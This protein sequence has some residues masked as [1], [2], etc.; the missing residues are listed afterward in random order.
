MRRPS[1]DSDIIPGFSDFHAEGIAKGMA[2]RAQGYDRAE[3]DIPA[4]VAEEGSS[5][6]MPRKVG[7]PADGN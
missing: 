7:E 1:V 5:T 4:A 6:L 3:E 2:S